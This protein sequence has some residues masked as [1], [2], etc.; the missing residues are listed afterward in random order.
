MDKIGPYGSIHGRTHRVR[1]GK[2]VSG[3][4][5]TNADSRRFVQ[6]LI[7][8]EIDRFENLQ[9]VF[10][11]ICQGLLCAVS[12]RDHHDAFE[13]GGPTGKSTVLRDYLEL[14]GQMVDRTDA[15]GPGQHFP[16]PY[17]VRTGPGGAYGPLLSNPPPL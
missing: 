16:T 5:G 15:Y 13:Q 11:E 3:S 6:L 4:I 9:A 14:D 8:S 7:V 17:A 10:Q 1:P 2:P 12:A